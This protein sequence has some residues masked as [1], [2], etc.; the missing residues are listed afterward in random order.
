MHPSGASGTDFKAASGPAQLKL[1]APDAMLGFPHGR[2]RSEADCGTA[3]HLAECGL[4]F[5]PL[6]L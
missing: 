5:G 4:H 2:L 6:A 1:R 3:G